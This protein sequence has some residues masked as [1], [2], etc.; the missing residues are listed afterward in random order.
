MKYKNTLLK[1]TRT[2][3]YA[4]LTFVMLFSCKKESMETEDFLIFGHFYGMCFGEECVETFKLTEDKLYEIDKDDYAHEVFNFKE[5]SEVQ[6][7]A[8]DGLIEQ[9]PEEI[10]S[11]H[12]QTFGCPDC[13]DQGGIY[14]QYK[15]ADD[16]KIWR[17]DQSKSNIPEFL[18]DFVDEVNATI[19]ETNS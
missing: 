9:I 7:K 18:H 13:A 16:F 17:I 6:F 4:F 2:F 8:A 12:L 10:Q 3:I 11:S 5:L 19:A 15:S 14:I 1:A